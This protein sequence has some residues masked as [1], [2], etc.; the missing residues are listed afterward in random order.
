MFAII[1][2][3]AINFSSEWGWVG[4]GL[5]FTLFLNNM[6][7]IRILSLFVLL[8]LGMTACKYDEGP[9]VS[10][11]SRKERVA[12]TWVVNTANINGTD[13]SEISG[14]KKI[15]FFSEG[16]CQIFYTTVFGDLA[17][18]GTWAFSEDQSSIH[19][20]L[21]DDL[22]HL[23]TYVNDWTILRLKD[24]ELKVSYTETPT[25]GS[26]DAYIVTFKPEA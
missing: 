14:F 12:N 5:G 8:A 7:N 4:L 16:A 20:D 17:Y 19:L 25:T 1:P 3:V 26:P 23:A 22:T 10:F 9:L 18:S 6:K 21:D 15:I 13:Q 2:F 11:V 24:K